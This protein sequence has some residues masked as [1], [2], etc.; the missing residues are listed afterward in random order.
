[1]FQIFGNVMIYK[2]KKQN[3]I[4]DLKYNI[5]YHLL[6]TETT[7]IRIIIAITANIQILQQTHLL[8]AFADLFAFTKF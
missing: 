5:L 3:K 7:T 1:M 4:N 2:N 6:I 8:W